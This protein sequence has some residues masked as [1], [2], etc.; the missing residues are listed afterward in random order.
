MM[1]S[2]MIGSVINNYRIIRKIGEGGMGVVF[3][4]ENIALGGQIRALKCLSTDLTINEMFCER[5]KYEAINQ[6]KLNHPNITMVYDF[7]T[8]E[9]NYFIVMEY[10]SGK[11]LI[12]LIHP[13]RDP[14]ETTKNKPITESQGLGYFKKILEG[15]AYIHSQN[16]IHRDIKPSNIK[17]TDDGVV[18]ILD[19]GIAM[20]EGGQRC[21]LTQS[22]VVIG[23]PHYMSP[24][25]IKRP[26]N[27]DHRSDIYSAGVVLFEILTREVPFDSK[28]DS[29][30]EIKDK[31]VRQ[32]PPN[33]RTLNPEIEPEL[34][35]VVLKALEKEPDNRFQNCEN[36]LEAL[37]NISNGRI[38]KPSQPTVIIS[39]GSR[40]PSIAP[41]IP[42]EDNRGQTAPKL[43]KKSPAGKIVLVSMSILLVLAVTVLCVGYSVE[44]YRF[45]RAKDYEANSSYS[46]QNKSDNWRSFKDGS[47][48]SKDR[49]YA[50]E[51][52]EELDKK[53]DDLYRSAVPQGFAE[54]PTGGGM[55]GSTDGDR[56]EIPVHAVQLGGI[57]MLDH[58]VTFQEYDSYCEI[59]GL[60]K[61]SDNGWGRE[62]LPVINVSWNEALLYCGWLS[63]QGDSLKYRLP[64]EAEWE[65]AC[66]SL[67]RPGL[68]AQNDSAPLHDRAWY[69]E[70]SGGRP[71]AVKQLAPNKFNLYDMQGNV[72]EWCQDWYDEFY[73]RFSPESQPSGP[74]T[75]AEKILR[76]GSWYDGAI[77]CR[78]T[79]RSAKHPATKSGNVGFR[80][81]RIAARK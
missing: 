35:K 3:E 34:V 48:L 50:V 74:E 75:G 16:L 73:Y 30:Y 22:G 33:P 61:P 47:W 11:G 12:Y 80:I 9:K 15:L 46:L 29:E 59:T 77:L 24:E 68:S 26:T 37:N 58:E 56:D 21:N 55:M 1:S 71:R 49:D 40:D 13:E 7:I 72:W 76:G 69:S 63:E 27:I 62:N 6:A 19:F 81:V 36:F 20:M 52:I 54:I 2:V 4:A 70:N 45:N 5:F 31:H 28:T 67:S 23:T 38:A 32:P 17:V 41:P 42:P 53:L 39:Q 66:R 60:I 14:D 57:S 25:Q 78:S 79:N 64:T 10:V 65:Y 43:R 8:Y 18:K 44:K 51:R